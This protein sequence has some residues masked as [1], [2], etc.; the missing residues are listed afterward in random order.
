MTTMKAARIHQFGS[1]E[2]VIINDVPQPTP[3]ADQ[4]LVHVH[5]AGI[6]PIDVAIHT[7]AIRDY[8]FD[9][10][11]LHTLGSEISGVVETVG[12]NVH[13]FRPGDA[14][15]AVLGFPGGGY[16]EYVAVTPD[17]L[18]H[19][20]AAVSHL[21][22]AGVPIA[23][24]AAWQALFEHAQLQRG[25]RVLVLAASGGVGTFAVQFARWAGAQVWGTTST[26]NLAFVRSLGATP[27]DYTAGPFEEAVRDIDLV[28][29][30]LAGDSQVRA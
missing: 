20:P 8:G 5:A 13:N 30:P 27:I 11:L 22:M 15:V 29:D 7:G 24:L 28:I 6:N 3:S 14:V 18:A 26:R 19:K 10:P 23:G 9:P 1:V 4:V 25:Q 12:A 16:A 21:H 17:L 2:S